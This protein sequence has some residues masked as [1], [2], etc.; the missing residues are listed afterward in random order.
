MIRAVAQGGIKRK[1]VF[2]RKNLLGITRADRA[3]HVRAHD[4]ALEKVH[5]VVELQA[6]EVEILP[7]QSGPV[8]IPLVVDSLIPDIV[9]R[10]HGTA[11]RKI[12]EARVEAAAQID[13]TEGAVPVVQMQN[14]RMQPERQNRLHHGAGKENETLGVVRV[15]RTVPVIKGGAVVEAVELD[16]AA[17]QI[18]L[19]L[20]DADLRPLVGAAE[21]HAEHFMDGIEFQ[22]QFRHLLRIVRHDDMDGVAP[23]R[24]RLRQCG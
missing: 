4:P 1:T 9:D 7:S 13:R 12:P 10:H 5:A 8:E 15:F 2:R 11:V 21:R 18:L 22:I 16:E 23:P 19:H 14:V 17:G 6:A 20:E 24:Q 3:D